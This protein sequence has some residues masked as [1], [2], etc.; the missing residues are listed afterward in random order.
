M[1]SVRSY[2]LYIITGTLKIFTIGLWSIT[3]YV[4]YHSKRDI[5][6]KYMVVWLTMHRNCG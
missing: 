3:V 5:S 4:S 6:G 2:I 1:R